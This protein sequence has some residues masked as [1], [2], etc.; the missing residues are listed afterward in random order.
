[1]VNTGRMT[2]TSRG[3]LAVASYIEWMRSV[4]R[5][6]ETTIRTRKSRLWLLA[7]WLHPT[8]LLDATEDDLR[9]WQSQAIAHLSIRAT[10]VALSNVDCFYAWAVKAGLVTTNP[11]SHLPRPKLPRRV[12]RP[13]TEPDVQTAL[14]QSEQP[15]RAMIALAAF[16]GLRCVEIASLQREDILDTADPPMLLV[17]GKG[18]VER[19]L[20]IGPHL[21]AELRA[22]GLPRSGPVFHRLDG[23]PGPLTANRVSGMISRQLKSLGIETTAHQARHRT[24]TVAYRATHDLRAVQAMLGHASPVTTSGYAMYADDALGEAMNAVDATLRRLV[25]APSPRR[26]RRG[27]PR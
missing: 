11:A 23:K 4:R 8:D 18:S 19:L 10:Y 16:A 9:T 1:M 13:M 26:E 3:G 17:H 27:S 12:P 14:A 20:P 15:Y 5:L 24:A 25:V 21:L 6:S 22:Y 7:E 2:Q